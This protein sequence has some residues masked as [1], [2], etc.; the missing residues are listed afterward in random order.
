MQQRNN[1]V[2]DFMHTDFMQETIILTLSLVESY[3]SLWWTY[4]R[5]MIIVITYV[6][7]I[8]HMEERNVFCFCAREYVVVALHM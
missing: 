4:L 6:A 5:H 8:I 1:Q 7:L 2:G 3:C